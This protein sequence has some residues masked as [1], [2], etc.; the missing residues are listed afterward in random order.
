MKAKSKYLIVCMVLILA[1]VC[2]YVM[3]QTAQLRA[4][5]KSHLLLGLRGYRLAE[6]GLCDRLKDRLAFLLYGDT[7]V[8]QDLNRNRF[9]GYFSWIFLGEPKGESWERALQEADVFAKGYRTNVIVFD[10]QKFIDDLNNQHTNANS[11]ANN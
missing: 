1:Y 3:G 11:K 9:H 5:T 10:K 6:L 4:D 2:G 7:V 8:Y